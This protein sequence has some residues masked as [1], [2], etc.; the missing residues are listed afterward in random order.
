MNG[1]F[2]PPEWLIRRWLESSFYPRVAKETMIR[3]CGRRWRIRRPGVDTGK[4]KS[5]MFTLYIDKKSKILVRPFSGNVP[6]DYTMIPS[7]ALEGVYKCVWILS[8]L[9]LV[10]A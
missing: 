8:G 10:L 5:L 9:V 3:T 4:Q 6:V 7:Y 2:A 1:A